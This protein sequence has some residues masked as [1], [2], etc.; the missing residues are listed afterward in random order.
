M[1][2]GQ[3]LSSL[4]R[5]EISGKPEVSIGPQTTVTTLPVLHANDVT[6][7]IETTAAADTTQTI[8]NILEDGRV[9]LI[10]DRELIPSAKR[11]PDQW[12]TDPQFPVPQVII[13]QVD[14]W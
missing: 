6:S 2:K 4:M 10:N 11:L 9:L 7:C 5:H 8:L 13:D 14:D 12:W 3:L 1:Y